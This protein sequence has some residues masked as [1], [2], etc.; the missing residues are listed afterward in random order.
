MT[1]SMMRGATALSASAAVAAGLL[2][3]GCGAGQVTQTETQ[4]PPISGVN[5]DSPDHKVLLRN[6][7]VVYTGPDGYPQGSTSSIQ[8]PVIEIRPAVHSRTKSRC[9]N[10]VVMTS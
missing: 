2:L 8:F 7:A 5:I 9:R 4:Q 10:G 1:R 6:L 3:A